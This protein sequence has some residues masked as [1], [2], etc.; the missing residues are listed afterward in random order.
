MDIT[1]EDSSSV[2]NITFLKQFELLA[3]CTVRITIDY[4]KL[5]SPQKYFFFLQV[6]SFLN[7]VV[8]SETLDYA[9]GYVTID[10]GTNIG[11]IFLG[12]ETGA[13]SNRTVFLTNELEQ[14]TAS[15]MI[16]V[17]MYEVD[18]TAIPGACKHQPP[19]LNTTTQEDVISFTFSQGKLPASD[20]CESDLSTAVA[21]DIRFVY[22]G[23]NEYSVQVYFDTIKRMLVG[24]NAITVGEAFNGKIDSNRPYQ[25]MFSRYAGMGLFFVVIL[26]AAENDSFI[27][28]SYVPSVSYGC[29]GPVNEEIHCDLIGETIC[30]RRFRFSNLI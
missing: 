7:E 5:S 11:K 22:S 27:P 8:I 23:K 26:R 17:L 28:I 15:I 6:H 9:T 21:Y 19:T 18:K 4:S 30:Q 2:N 24:S 13:P 10:R 3:N 20:S 12:N 29:P 16:V 14:K 1:L 25:R